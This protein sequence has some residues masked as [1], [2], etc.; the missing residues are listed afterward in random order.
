MHSTVKRDQ[1]SLA[2]SWNTKSVNAG[3]DPVDYRATKPGEIMGGFPQI[4]DTAIVLLEV[5]K[6]PVL[7]SF[8]EE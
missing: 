8:E 3:R 2:S 1:P 6:K 5:I 4:E 7:P